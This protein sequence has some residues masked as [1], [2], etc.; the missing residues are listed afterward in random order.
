MQD[1]FPIPTTLCQ[2]LIDCH[3]FSDKKAEECLQAFLKKLVPEGSDEVKFLIP[4]H[5]TVPTLQ[6]IADWVLDKHDLYI[7]VDYEIPYYSSEINPRGFKYVVLDINGESTY[8]A[9]KWEDK[10]VF[11]SKDE[12]LIT[13]IT[14]LFK[15]YDM[16]DNGRPL[17]KEE[18]IIDGITFHLKQNNLEILKE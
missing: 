16:A 9:K 2:Q 3:F 8:L 12:A 10:T 11:K 6:E 18:V 14:K 17:P 15:E 1:N 13:A 4:N 5:S 7:Q